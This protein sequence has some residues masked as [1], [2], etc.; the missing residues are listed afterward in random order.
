MVYMAPG[1]VVGVVAMV[2]CLY[3]SQPVLEHSLLHTQRPGHLKPGHMMVGYGRGWYGMVWYGMTM[4]LGYDMR[5]YSMLW[6]G[7]VEYAKV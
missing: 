4:Y 2:V 3:Q 6:Y 1:V 7:K 5:W